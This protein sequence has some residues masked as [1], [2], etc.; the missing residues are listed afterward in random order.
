MSGIVGF[1]DFE[2]NLD[3]NIL[4][5]MTDRLDHRG[6]TKGYSFHEN[7]NSLIGLGHRGLS[8]LDLTTNGDQPMQFQNLEI[9][10]NGEVYNFK[11]IR[12]EL[13]IHNY[14]FISNSDTEVIL[15]AYHKWGIKAVDK[16]N[17]MFAIAIFDNIKQKLVLLRDR[18]GVKPCYYYLDD[19]IF[20]FSSE[21]KSFHENKS[22]KKEIDKDAL[23][24]YMR[25]GYIP[26]PYSI[27]KNTYK[28]KAGH[29]LEFN[30]ATRKVYESKYWDVIDFYN[31]PKLNISDQD[32]I[33]E[34]ENL[35]KSAFEYR[36][37]SDV[38]VGI[39]LSGGYDSATVAAILQQNRSDKLKTFTIGFHEKKY[40]ET[41]FAR[42]TSEYLGT[43]HTEY[44]CTQ[45]DT[46]NII[47]KLP[48]IYDEPIGDNS[49][50]STI[51]VSQIAKKEVDVCLSADGGEIFGGRNKYVSIL[52][53]FSILQK[54]PGFLKPFMANV[55]RH[56]FIHKGLS[57]FGNMYD[58]KT[59]CNRFADILTY[60]EKQILKETGIFSYDELLSILN[61]KF[62][63]LKT[64][65][66][67]QINQHQ[68][69]NILGIDQ[70]TF[71]VDDV[72][73]K[74]DRATMSATLQG[75]EPLLDHRIIEFIA[76]L[77]SD[78]KIRNG[79]T[80]WI[81]KEIAH[82]YLP[83]K[84]MKRDKKGFGV[85]MQKWLKDDLREYLESY[86]TEKTLSEHG[87]FDIQEVSKMKNSYI[88]GENINVTKLWYILIFQMWYK[89][90]M[91]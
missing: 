35:F 53:K 42:Q 68:V 57:V 89:K 81:L 8:S 85:P 50:I 80:K 2:K 30:L 65:F 6:P 37:V 82:K 22:F 23:S 70:K 12:N 20:M 17:G 46:F 67:T 31:K 26:E 33:H 13:E 52:N 51:L 4:K 5:K 36:M 79:T 43:N 90:W 16:F 11:E 3:K 21:L 9:V 24:L 25:Y 66:D 91:H 73:H 38:P 83:K 72:L 47:K 69:S 45:Q 39:F 27:F 1:C 61:Y 84:M 75:R 64:N 55:L 74:V 41:L 77:P 49:V 54:I 86:L 18:A 44:Y 78:K 88:Q 48:E 19:S 29:F 58:S 28:L 63:E 32:A 14:S 71:L 10:Y 59:R 7:Q 60:D 34:L 62:N 40:D 56:Q 87:L 76:Q 15:K